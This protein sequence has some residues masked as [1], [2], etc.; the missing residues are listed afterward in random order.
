MAKILVTG[1]EGQ[2]GHELR[3]VLERVMPGVT[4]YVDRADIDLTDRDAVETLSLIHI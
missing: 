1:S 2:L 3:S 4:T